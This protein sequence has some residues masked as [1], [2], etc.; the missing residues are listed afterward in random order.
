MP[1]FCLQ[2]EHTRLRTDTLSYTN[3]QKAFD[4]ANTLASQSRNKRLPFGDKNSPEPVLH[5]H[6]IV[7]FPSSLLTIPA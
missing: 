6:F 2:S 4:K 1:P 7:A 3:N 5:L